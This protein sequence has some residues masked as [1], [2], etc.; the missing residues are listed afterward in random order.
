MGQECPL[1]VIHIPLTASGISVK[2]PEAKHGNW[3]G[4]C[5]KGFPCRPKLP[6][7]PLYVDLCT[8]KEERGKHVHAMYCR[9]GCK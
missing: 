2:S 1:H 3:A 9:W 5:L 8:I 7:I 4:N 6:E